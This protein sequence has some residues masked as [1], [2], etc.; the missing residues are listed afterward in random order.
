[1]EGVQKGLQQIL[2]ARARASP[3]S[4][5][6]PLPPPPASKAGKPNGPKVSCSGEEV[7]GMEPEVVQSALAAGISMEH[8]LEMEAILRGKP[9]RI[10]K[11]LRQEVQRSS[12][13][14]RG[15]RGGRRRGWGCSFRRVW[16]PRRWRWECQQHGEGHRQIDCH[17]LEAC[18]TQRQ[19]QVGSASGRRQW[20]S[21]WSREQLRSGFQKNA[22]VMRAH[23]QCDGSQPA[24]AGHAV[25][26]QQL[27]QDPTV[28][29]LCEMGMADSR[30]FG[31]AWSQ[32]G[33]TRPVRDV[34]CSWRQPTKP[35]CR[36]WRC[37]SFEMPTKRHHCWR[38]NAV[39]STAIGGQ[40]P[41]WVIWR[42]WTR[43]WTQR[44]SLAAEK[45]RARRSQTAAH[46][47]KPKLKAK[48]KE[49]A[50]KRRKGQ[51]TKPSLVACADMSPLGEA[52]PSG[53][54]I[55]VRP[56]EIH[57]PGSRAS[58]FSG[59]GVLQALLR[60]LLKSR[61]CPGSLHLRKRRW[62][63]LQKSFLYFCPAL[64]FSVVGLMGATSE[65]SSWLWITSFWTD[66]NTLEM[67][68]E[69]GFTDHSRTSGKVESLE[70]SLSEQTPAKPG[71][72][73]FGS[74]VQ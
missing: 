54:R 23:L 68:L 59:R 69:W 11:L 39:F 62:G 57:V 17:S 47:A 16:W 1:M 38:L 9:R 2:G 18:W 43:L 21:K 74:P 64:R 5:A 51:D 56:P 20:W 42:R 67:L 48:S 14:K 53:D 45:E 28:P 41:F 8:L 70:C 44:R 37:C 22:A 36:M 6:R 61:C 60:H 50:D 52:E 7:A 34:P 71:A 40:R 65:A 24:E 10:E 3:K 25:Q 4:L 63:A 66:P 49:D 29:Q 72:S 35:A 13:R 55:Q 15:R 31:T 58:A 33:T 30:Y 19:E 73:Y 32:G 26:G 27:S 46:Q 12:Q